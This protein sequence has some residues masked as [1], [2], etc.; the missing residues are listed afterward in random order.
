MIAKTLSAIT[1]EKKLLWLRI[2]LGII[3]V[4]FGAL[5][6]VP[7]L[8]PADALA[9]DTIDG[10]FLHLIPRQFSILLL[11]LIEVSIGLLFLSNLYVRLAIVMA[12]FH[13]ACTFT[14]FLLLPEASFTGPLTFTLVGQYIMKNIVFIVGLLLIWPEK[15]THKINENLVYRL[16]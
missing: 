3:Y 2:T 11:A 15:T 7:E 8:S 6:F 14:P 5:K 13:M 9:K 10:L 16:N 12:L 4:W 1:L